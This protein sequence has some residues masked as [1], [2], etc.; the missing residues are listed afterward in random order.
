MR[1]SGFSWEAI[2]KEYGVNRAMARLL[3]N[4]YRPGKKIRKRLNLPMPASVIII[5]EGEIPDGSQAIK[6]L[7]CKCGQ[8]FIPNHPLRT[9]CFIC[10]PSKTKT[11]NKV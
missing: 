10:R 8:W 3:G 4:G 7:Q 9:H 5:G 2:G 1:S 6:A 11:K